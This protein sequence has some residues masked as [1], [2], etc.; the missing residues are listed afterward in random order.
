MFLPWFWNDCEC[1]FW[2]S[3][4]VPLFCTWGRHG[5]DG[6]YVYKS[7][8]PH[9]LI[10]T[11]KTHHTQKC[12][13]FYT[14]KTSYQE[15]IKTQLWSNLKPLLCS[16]RKMREKIT[17]LSLLSWALTTHIY[18]CILKRKAHKIV[19]FFFYLCRWHMN[20]HTQKQAYT[21]QKAI[22]IT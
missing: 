4:K 9:R 5:H 15:S 14:N 21:A 1:Y 12:V 13:K 20:K 6:H 11:L 16:R 8:H 2:H 19:G 18:Q 10:S 3:L 7:K 22:D 17:V